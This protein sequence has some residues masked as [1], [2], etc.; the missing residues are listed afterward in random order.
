MTAAYPNSYQKGTIAENLV[1]KKFTSQG[2]SI[3]ASNYRHIGFEIDFI[4]K[5]A[6]T[7]VFVEIKYRKHMP[8]CLIEILSIKKKQALIRGAHHYFAHE[9]N[10][11]SFTTARFDLIIVTKK[12]KFVYFPGVLEFD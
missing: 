1:K 8:N 6:E 9:Q 2:F 4:A 10:P 5:K 12:N 7:I 3:L 11:I